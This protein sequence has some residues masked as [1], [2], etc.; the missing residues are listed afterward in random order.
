MD[1][2]H[3]LEVFVNEKQREWLKHLSLYGLY[4][5]TEGEVAEYLIMRGLDDLWRAGV[6]GPRS[7]RA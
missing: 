6:I 2:Q 3:F 1:E 4:G 7:E 5:E